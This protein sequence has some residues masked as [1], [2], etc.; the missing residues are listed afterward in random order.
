MAAAVSTVAAPGTAPPSASLEARAEVAPDRIESAIAQRWRRIAE[1]AK[2]RRGPPVTRAFLWNLIVSGPFEVTGALADELVA[3][4]PTRAIVIARP[5]DGDG[6]LHTFV[7][8][9]LASSGGHAVGSDEI[10]IQIGG[11]EELARAALARVPSLVRSVLVPDALAALVWIGA[12]PPRDHVTR[13]FLGEVDRLILDS[14]RIPPEPDG[15]LALGAILSLQQRYPKLE[16]ADLAWL[17]ISPLR[18]LL[19]A[20]FDPPHDAAPLAALDEVNV[21]SGVDGVQVR[22]LLMLGWLGARLRWTE[23]R[24]QA[25][26]QAGERIF[27]ATRADGKPVRMRLTTDLRGARHG[28]RVL[29]LRAGDR[30]WSLERDAEKIEVHAPELPP[31]RQPARSH[32]VGER[33]AQALGQKGRDANYR[34]ALAFAAALAGAV[35]T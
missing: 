14:R 27:Y 17:G 6:S 31:R 26:T 33:L 4:L 29:E 34:D 30:R 5:E 21:V 20:L 25:A 19:A 1:A 16:I 35:A 10:I 3:E 18:G 7:E 15:E 13:V 24:Q 11:S 12:P 22:A 23:A 28:V 32:T 9:N 8:T 2:E